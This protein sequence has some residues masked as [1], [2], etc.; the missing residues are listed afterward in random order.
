[1]MVVPAVAGYMF[2]MLFQSNGPVNQILSFLSNS[3]VELVWLSV[4]HLALAAVIA[5]DVWNGRHW[6]S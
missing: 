5:A 6:F 1:M 4:P 2:Y 3:K